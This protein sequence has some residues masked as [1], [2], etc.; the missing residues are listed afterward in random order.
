MSNP[1]MVRG[2]GAAKSLPGT[3]AEPQPPE[4]THGITKENLLRSLPVAL[5]GDPKIVALADA[6]AGVLAQRLEEI[7]RASIYPRI[8]WLDEELLDILA[9][10]FKVD[11]WDSDYSLEEKRRTLS[12]SWQVHKTLGTKAA[13]EKAIRAVYPKTQVREWFEYGGN[14]YCFRLEIDITNDTKNS[15]KQQ[16]VLKLLN[17]YKSL[18]SH[19]DSLSYYVYFDPAVLENRNH[20][21]FISMRLGMRLQEWAITRHRLYDFRVSSSLMNSNSHALFWA[22]RWSAEERNQGRLHQLTALFH[23]P[24]NLGILEYRLNGRHDLDGSWRLGDRVGRGLSMVRFLVNWHS[25][26]PE[27]VG[28]ILLLSA[29]IRSPVKGFPGVRFG[30]AGVNR[31]GFV[32]GKMAASSHVDNLQK[33]RAFVVADTRWRLDGSYQLNGE[34]RL[35]ADIERSEL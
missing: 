16:R 9:Q 21:L 14:P 11:W 28:M 3:G 34:K 30:V 19:L 17:Y 18:R 35:K 26:S 32:Q 2:A 15:Q 31:D 1:L 20:L 29:R 4:A 24:N 25:E 10:D 6:I 12:T 22:V 27:R 13:V 8:D 23:G 33:A 7:R 5:S